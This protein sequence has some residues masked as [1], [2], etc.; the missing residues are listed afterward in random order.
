M[1]N[2]KNVAEK[3]NKRVN[4]GSND[5]QTIYFPNVSAY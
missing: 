5:S 1:R 2:Q 3:E 4:H